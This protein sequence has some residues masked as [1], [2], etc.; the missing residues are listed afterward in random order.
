MFLGHLT[1]LDAKA[2]GDK[3][4]SGKRRPSGDVQG[5]VPQGPHDKAKA[6]LL[7]VQSPVVKVRTRRNNV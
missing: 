3:S 6:G 2:R 5:G 7:E 1:Y 4:M